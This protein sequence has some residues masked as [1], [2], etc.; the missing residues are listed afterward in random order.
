MVASIASPMVTRTLTAVEHPRAGLRGM[1]RRT[2]AAPSSRAAI[3]RRETPVFSDGL[4]RR[5]DPGEHE[6]R[7]FSQ[8][9]LGGRRN[10]LKRLISRKKRAWIF[11]P[12]GLDFALPLAWISFP[13]SAQKEKLSGPTEL[14]GQ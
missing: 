1:L 14:D 4:W 5:S 2:K 3:G 13:P 7:T 11:L 6:A 10:P 8:N 12:P 9:D